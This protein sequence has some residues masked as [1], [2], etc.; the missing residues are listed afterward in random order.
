MPSARLIT[1]AIEE[2]EDLAADL[3]NRGYV[4]EIV[5]PDYIPF[6]SVDL[7][8]RLE[9]SPT[10]IALR[11]AEELSKTEDIHVFIAPG[12]IVESLR[13]IVSV[14]LEVASLQDELPTAAGLQEFAEPIEIGAESRDHAFAAEEIAANELIAQPL[15]ELE[16]T[17]VQPQLYTQ[18]TPDVFSQPAEVEALEVF[19]QEEQV[20]ADVPRGEAAFLQEEITATNDELPVLSSET[21]VDE[22]AYAFQ[23]QETPSPV[24]QPEV[25]EIFTQEEPLATEISSSDNPPLGEEIFAQEDQ[26]PLAAMEASVNQPAYALESHEAFPPSDWPIWQPLAEE[27]EPEL[28]TLSADVGALAG[29][30]R[31]SVGTFTRKHNN[32]RL[33][34]RLAIVASVVAVSTMLLGVSAHRFSPIPRGLAADDGGL[35]FKSKTQLVPATTVADAATQS[36]PVPPSPEFK[37]VLAHMPVAD[38]PSPAEHLGSRVKPPKGYQRAAT[39][40]EDDFVAR[41]TTVRFGKKPV[42]PRIQA[43]KQSGIRHYSD[44][45]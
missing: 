28:A 39:R 38:R 8:V 9:E 32:D 10:E 31:R 2:A 25:E 36:A 7:E 40:R 43:E 19:A 44:L 3:R 4:V 29:S 15:P 26:Q 24:S 11:S 42:T 1:N 5:S 20:T 34:W 37:R 17:V 16:A 35:P 12:A 13:P 18:E 41:D 6:H 45:R 30:P 33:F 21:A 23:S 27:H 22:S 14:P